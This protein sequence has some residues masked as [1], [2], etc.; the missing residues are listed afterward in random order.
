MA[1]VLALIFAYS[2][3]YAPRVGGPFAYVS[4]AFNDFYGFLAG[5]SMWIAEV[6][7]LPVFAI[8]FTNYL[9]YFV[10]LNVPEQ[11]GVR[12]AFLFGL[13][14]VNVG[15]VRAASRLNDALTFIKLSPLILLIVAGIGSF[16]V[17]PSFFLNYD[18]LAPN[19][20]GTLWNSIV[21]I[22]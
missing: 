18:H 8:T 4:E 14:A 22:L 12:A 20:F 7:S 11:L 2:A 19:G 9:Q 6:I 10:M 21:I 16:A 17:S 13:T 1:M 5:W 15:G 3:F